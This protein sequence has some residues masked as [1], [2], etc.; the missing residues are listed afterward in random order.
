STSNR[1]KNV[2]RECGSPGRSR[3]PANAGWNPTSSAR[4]AD[5]RKPEIR[6]QK[7]GIR[8]LRLIRT[9]ASHLRF[10]I[11]DFRTLK[12]EEAL[13]LHAKLMERET[14][15]RPIRVGLIGAGKFGTMFL[16][17]ARR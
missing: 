15:G 17:Q 1:W 2:R 10:L 9:F 12:R 13:N 16:A 5:D 6:G 14:A 3:R 4:S 8:K 11:S 7:S